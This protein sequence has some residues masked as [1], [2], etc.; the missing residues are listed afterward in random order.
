M[1]P[2]AQPNGFHDTTS[3]PIGTVTLPID[4]V[5]RLMEPMP[6]RGYGSGGDYGDGRAENEPD[7]RRNGEYHSTPMSVPLARPWEFDEVQHCGRPTA[8]EFRHEP[9]RQWDR[10]SPPIDNASQGAGRYTSNGNRPQNYSR[11]DNPPYRPMP[12]SYPGASQGMYPPG[13]R[14]RNHLVPTSSTHSS[15]VLPGPSSLAPYS[16]V[17]SFNPVV[18]PNSAPRALLDI[19]K[20]CSTLVARCAILDII[21]M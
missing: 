20:P 2:A 11:T 7:D 13:P 6:G 14:Q 12:L 1:D 21:T 4:S 18:Y 16:S 9:S 5:G 10:S 3:P 8:T 15:E 17:S 19:I